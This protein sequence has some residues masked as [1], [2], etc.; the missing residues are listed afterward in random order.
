[1][2][3]HARS[4]IYRLVATLALSL[5]IVALAQTPAVSPAAL[6]GLD[7]RAAVELA[8]AWKGNDVTSFVTSDVVHFVFPDG[9]EV[10][11]ALPEHE[12]MVSVAPYFTHTHPCIT[13]YMSGCQGELVGAPVHVLAIAP[14]GSVLIDE[15][16]PT[17]ANGFLDLW[18]P[19]DLAIELQL[20]L[21]GYRTIGRITTHAG[22][23]TCVT[24][25]QF[26]AAR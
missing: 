11:I 17:P 7:A 18:L 16:M 4:S 8:N 22:S 15:V 9:A 10:S 26:A 6:A 12:M 13:H 25:L 3:T 24:T 19:R 14:D 20:S 21:D 2:A 1:M 23:D 5:S